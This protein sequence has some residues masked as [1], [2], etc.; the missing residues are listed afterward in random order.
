[1]PPFEALYGR[2]CNLIAKLES[3]AGSSNP[4]GK[5]PKKAAE[6]T[7]TFWKSGPSRY[8]KNLRGF[9]RASYVNQLQIQG[10]SNPQLLRKAK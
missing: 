2:K 6:K 4:K 8:A 3:G 5:T 9:S 1:M 10:V 7:E